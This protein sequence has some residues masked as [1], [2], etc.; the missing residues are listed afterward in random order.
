MSKPKKKPA[1]KPRT[2]SPITMSKPDVTLK[3][4]LA[5]G[6]SP[7]EGFEGVDIWPQSKH[8]VNLMQYPWP[9]EDNSVDELHCSHFAEHIPM[10]FVDDTGA[11]VSM[12]MEGAKEAMFKFFDECHRILRPEGWMTVIVPCARSNRGFQDPTHRRFFVAESFLYL[13]KQ[14]RDINKLDHYNVACDFGI[15]VVP[16]IPTELA[17]LSPEVQ[18]R[19]FNGEWNTVL[20]WQAKLKAIK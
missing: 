10:I 14:W 5:A 15:D 16:I 2:P 1:A 9:F 11:E 19:R 13:S 6:Q 12:G 18:H 8:V 17:V 7:R 3:L 20:D 4:D